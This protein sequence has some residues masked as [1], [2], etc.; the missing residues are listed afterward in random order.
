MHGRSE[1]EGY[2]W[3]MERMSSRRRRSVKGP[4]LD[5][6]HV[7]ER[8]FDTFQATVSDSKRLISDSPLQKGPTAKLTVMSI[9]ISR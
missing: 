6:V 1:R 3:F 4:L 8:F 7:W 2:M 9:R 5:A